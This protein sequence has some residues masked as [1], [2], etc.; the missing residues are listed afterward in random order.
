[1]V[2]VEQTGSVTSGQLGQFG[3]GAN[4]PGSVRDFVGSE[5]GWLGVTA[6]GQGYA[7]ELS[8]AAL[9]YGVAELK[10][11]HIFAVV[12]PNHLASIRVL[13]KVGMRQ[14]DV[15]MMYLSNRRAWCTKP[16]ASWMTTNTCSLMSR[17]GWHR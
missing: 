8:K 3:I 2:R 9:K 11:R 1:M 16:V 12:S 6:W 13:E 7:T 17:Q 5:W 10:V 4:S 14:V 15:L